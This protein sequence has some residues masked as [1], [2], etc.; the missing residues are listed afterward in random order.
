MVCP[1]RPALHAKLDLQQ[2]SCELELAC[3]MN[4]LNDFGCVGW[5]WARIRVKKTAEDL[6]LGKGHDAV[7]ALLAQWKRPWCMERGCSAAA[8][9]RLTCDAS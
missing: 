7:V 9:W 1:V 8:S 2:M 5:G 4:A 6:A 3:A